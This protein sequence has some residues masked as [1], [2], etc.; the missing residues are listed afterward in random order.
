MCGCSIV[1]VQLCRSSLF[2]CYWS[3]NSFLHLFGVMYLSAFLIAPSLVAL[4]EGTKSLPHFTLSFFAAIRF[5]VLVDEMSKVSTDSLCDS[6]WMITICAAH[7]N[8]ATFCFFL[9]RNYVLVF[10]FFFNDNHYVVVE[11]T[12]YWSLFKAPLANVGLLNRLG[13]MCFTT[14]FSGGFWLWEVG[15]VKVLTYN[16]VFISW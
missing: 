14:C 9:Q 15:N 13:L 7:E 6:V 4:T 3:F 11:D 8:S 10:F 1:G 5:H 12:D 16:V 2:F